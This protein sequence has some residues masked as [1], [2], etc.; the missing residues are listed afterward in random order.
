MSSVEEC[1]KILLEWKQFIQKA[2]SQ[3][4]LLT[5]FACECQT[6]IWWDEMVNLLGV[7]HRRLQTRSLLQKKD[8]LQVLFTWLWIGLKVQISSKSLSPVHSNY[9]IDHGCLPHPLFAYII[10]ICPNFNILGLMD[11]EMNC[12]KYMLKPVLYIILCLFTSEKVGESWWKCS[13]IS[14]ALCL[15]W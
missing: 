10:I 5:T 6:V 13:N 1:N 4:L 3:N 14:I 11:F 15:W 7:S 12:L 8:T 2:L 9:G